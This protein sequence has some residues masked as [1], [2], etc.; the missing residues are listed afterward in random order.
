MLEEMRPVA[1]EE[2]RASFSTKLSVEEA[3]A[4]RESLER[5]RAAA[6]SPD[7]AAT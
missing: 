5:V 2:L 3:D 7:G 6:C 1:V 4:M